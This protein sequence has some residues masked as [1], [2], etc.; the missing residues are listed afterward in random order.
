MACQLGPAGV[1]GLH[2]VR[3]RHTGLRAG[4]EAEGAC[5]ETLEREEV[6]SGLKKMSGVSPN[7]GDL[8]RGQAIRRSPVSGA[9][10]AATQP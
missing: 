4:G 2:E 7:R 5:P 9:N 10:G 1:P 6:S 8:E 3:D